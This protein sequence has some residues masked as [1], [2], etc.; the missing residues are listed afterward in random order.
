MQGD[1][2]ERE[3]ET[4][5]LLSILELGNRQIE[6]GRVQPAGVVIARLRERGQAR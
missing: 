3:Q 4:L 6:K 1:S 5:A 2:H